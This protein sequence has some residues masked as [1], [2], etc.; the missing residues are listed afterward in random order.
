M[1]GGGRDPGG[2]RGWK[3]VAGLGTMAEGEK[4]WLVVVVEGGV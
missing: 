2:G 1:D 3:A 4:G